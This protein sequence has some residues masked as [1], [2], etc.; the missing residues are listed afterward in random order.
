MIGWYLKG[1]YTFA[2]RK[3]T[4]AKIPTPMAYTDNR[5]NKA[6]DWTPTRWSPV[7]VQNI[8]K[9]ARAYLGQTEMVFA[10]EAFTLTYPPLIT[11]EMYQRI[12]RR[13]K[14]RTLKH[15]ARFLSTGFLDCSCGAHM[16]ERNSHD[17]HFARCA[18]RCGH[19]VR[20][21]ALSAALWDGTIN[22][23]VEIQKTEQTRTA[24]KNQFRERLE[25][26]KQVLA[27]VMA[28]ILRLSEMYGHGLD[29]DTWKARNDVL[30]ESKVQ[31]QNEME[32][33]E[34]EQQEH[35]SRQA[36]QETL[37][38]RISKLVYEILTTPHGLEK[39]GKCS[40][41]CWPATG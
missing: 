20:E 39:N 25:Q 38:A 11:N 30:N 24:N 14:E 16:H 15:G 22:R 7:T 34:R 1:G 4:E 31:A 6:D 13:R 2:A 33:I 40:R 18:R 5:R 3:A 23:L 12:L 9:N 26:A 35:E 29:K 36:S 32:A 8:A 37:E 27:S 17:R 19:P 41:I 21:V 10:G 28:D